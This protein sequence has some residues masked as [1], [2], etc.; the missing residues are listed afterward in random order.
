MACTLR[1]WPARGIPLSRE[2]KHEAKK[3]SYLGL[4][5]RHFASHKASS[6]T[7]QRKRNVPTRVWHGTPDNVQPPRGHRREPQR[8]GHRQGRHGERT[9]L[10]GRLK[11]GSQEL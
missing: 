1:I 10:Y 8:A 6:G 4:S 7:C 11:P 9:T 5:N 3:K 2:D